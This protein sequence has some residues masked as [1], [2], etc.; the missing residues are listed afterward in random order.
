MATRPYRN[1]AYDTGRF[2]HRRVRE[3]EQNGCG[4]TVIGPPTFGWPEEDGHGMFM[5]KTQ[6]RSYGL[7]HAL[8]REVGQRGAHSNIDAIPIRNMSVDGVFNARP[9]RGTCYVTDWQL[10][11]AY[12]FHPL[13][14]MGYDKK[15]TENRGCFDPEQ[16]PFFI[17]TYGGR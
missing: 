15:P 5:V 6:E 14:V 2:P 8:L 13:S 1:S 12:P 17:S 7:N 16:K 11:P 3:K 9:D 10:Q 4:G